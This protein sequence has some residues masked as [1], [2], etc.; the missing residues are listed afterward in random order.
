MFRLGRIKANMFLYGAYQRLLSAW[1]RCHNPKG[2]IPPY[3][4]RIGIETTNRCNLKCDFCGYRFATREKGFI[5]QTLFNKV[6]DQTTKMSVRRLTLHTVGEPL[7]HP[8]IVDLVS[9]AKGNGVWVGFSTNGLLLTRELSRRLIE[10][11]LD[12]ISFSTDAATDDVYRQLRRGGNFDKLVG[13]IR[14][15]RGMREHYGKQG[16]DPYKLHRTIKKP[17]IAITCIYTNKLKNQLPEYLRLFYPLADSFKFMSLDVQGGYSQ[18]DHLYTPETKYDEFLKGGS[19][20]FRIP[21]SLLWSSLFVLW[22]GD[23]S[24]CCFDFDGKMVVGNVNKNSLHQIWHSERA[25]YYRMLH[26][27]NRMEALEMCRSCTRLFRNPH[28]EFFF[29]KDKL[30]KFGYKVK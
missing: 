3:P 12:G 21:C 20:F 25:N 26:L 16:F 9:T 22:N 17:L 6:I 4:L 5:P 2:K 23:V 19:K 14:M 27:E 8:N 18:I 28:R 7:L 13:N 11:G 29:N 15:F 10:V 30:D 1:H 24:M